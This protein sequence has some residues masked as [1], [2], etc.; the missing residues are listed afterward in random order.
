MSFPAG[1]R[2]ADHAAGG[3]IDLLQS[4]RS[5]LCRGA[6]SRFAARLPH[7]DAQLLL[8]AARNAYLDA[9]MLTALLGLARHSTPH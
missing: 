4:L 5:G 3:R 7:D 2:A 1:R 8:A 9:F 6:L